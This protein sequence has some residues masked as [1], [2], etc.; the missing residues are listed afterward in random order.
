MPQEKA[1]PRMFFLMQVKD[2]C[3]PQADKHMAVDER[4]S[5]DDA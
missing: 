2:R 4:S 5:G 1:A 3:A